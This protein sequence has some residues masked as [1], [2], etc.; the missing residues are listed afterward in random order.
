MKKIIIGACTLLIT[1]MVSPVM[2]QDSR[3]ERLDRQGDRIN[4]E[5][6]RRGDRI[7]RMLDR[8]GNRI[9][10]RF[11]RN[12]NMARKAGKYRLARKMERQG[13]R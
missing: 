5:L 10:A 11:D 9:E 12:A 8:K 7:N 4:R 1:V 6:D 13:D 2:A 3:A